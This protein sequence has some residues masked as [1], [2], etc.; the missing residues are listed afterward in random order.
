MRR[1]VFTDPHTGTKVT[2]DLEE[3]VVTALGQK[4]PDGVAFMAL[5]LGRHTLDV[6]LHEVTELVAPEEDNA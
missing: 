4:Y 5:V 1:N 2:V 3:A 6:L